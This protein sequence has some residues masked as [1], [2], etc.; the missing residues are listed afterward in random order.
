MLLNGNY[1]TTKI[2]VHALRITTLAVL[3]QG[4][5]YTLHSLRR[6]AT[7]A[8]Q[9][10]GLSVDHIMA[11]GMWQSNAINTYLQPLYVTTAPAALSPCLV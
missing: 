8:C 10:G 9:N 3:G 2:L 6:G 4:R 5:K 7:K 11:V 1:L